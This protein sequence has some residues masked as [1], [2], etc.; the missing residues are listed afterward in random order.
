MTAAY[1]NVAPLDHLALDLELPWH[2]QKE[3]QDQFI[4][5]IKKVVAPIMIFLLVMPL[6]PDLTGEEDVPEKV[7]AKVLLDP[8]KLV[9]VELPKLKEKKL[10]VRKV[11]DERPDSK[12]K[13]GASNGVP[14]M[15]ALSQQLSALRNS[16]N[17]NKIQ[18][19]NVFEA[20]VGK[21]Q[22]SS[23]A[24][25][26]KDS[27]TAS[28]GGLKASDIT[29]NAKG[30]ALEGY[31]SSQVESSIANIELPS[32]AEYHYDPSKRAKRDMQSIRRTIERYKG[33]VYSQYAKALRI[34]PDLAGRFIFS[35]VIMPD[36]SI[37]E[38]KLKSSEL[39]DKSLET[40]L[41][42]K[43][44]KINFGKEDTNATAVEYTY[45][46]LPS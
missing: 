14:N 25:L 13:E 3:Q 23:R 5:L 29:V 19:K 42:N 8:P 39:G 15:A 34:N 9:P 27:A 1:A 26:G 38:L 45:T 20:S 18:N 35:F 6:L 30:A 40:K 43:I 33:S 11:Q 10:P 37:N 44:Q 46:F 41:L 31:S 22:K 28:S 12:P 2:D 7:V 36:G 21:T 24:M 17:L 16:V 4:R 32:A